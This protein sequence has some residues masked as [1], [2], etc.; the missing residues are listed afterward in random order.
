[1]PEKRFIWVGLIGLLLSPWV[2]LSAAHAAKP[3]IAVMAVTADQL[4]VAVRAKLD[5]ALAGGLAASGADVVDAVATG[6]RVD[7]KGLAGCETSTC[8][9]AI[10]E[11]TGARYLMRGSV[12]SMGRSYTVRLEMID[13][14]SGGV[15]GMREDRCEICT[16][17][18]VYETASMSAS[19]LKSD[20][21][22]RAGKTGTTTGTT[23]GT[24]AAAGTATGNGQANGTD[25][26]LAG[27]PAGA[28]GSASDMPTLVTPASGYPPPRAPR[29]RTLSWM[30]IGAG[31]I[32]IGAGVY[33]LS[34]NDELTCTHTPKQ[35]CPRTW[36]TRPGSFSAIGAGVLA[37]ALGTTLLIGRF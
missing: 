37:V 1:M 26:A 22:K 20:I 33:F 18:D 10:A 7:D 12:E 11:A 36:S 29:W 4:S 2:T 32:S 21:W 31:A 15:I 3:R 14:V 30:S 25:L 17:S 16:E 8:R 6:K 19:T 9:V 28:G 13:G 24:S 35:A 5:N 23:T 34:L 27:N